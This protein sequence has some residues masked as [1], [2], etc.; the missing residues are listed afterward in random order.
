MLRHHDITNVLREHLEDGYSVNV[1]GE[2]PTSGYMVGG[3]VEALELS[4]DH[5]R[6]YLTTD[7]WLDK[8]W[9]YFSRFP[10]EYYAGIWKDS[11]TGITYVDISRNVEDIHTAVGIALSRGEIA[12]WDVTN[13]KE[14]RT[15]WDTL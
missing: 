13:G 5:P 3:E 4:K 15:D 8:H 1:Y 9:S 2:V 12:V 10:A 14:I 7:A 6:P 11:E